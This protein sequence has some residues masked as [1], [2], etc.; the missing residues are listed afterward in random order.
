MFVMNSMR[1]LVRAYR[2]GIMGATK[3]VSKQVTACG[4]TV[5][6]SHVGQV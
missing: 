6:L 1:E 2:L 5:Y 3:A 4:I